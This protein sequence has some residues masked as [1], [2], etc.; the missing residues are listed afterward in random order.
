MTLPTIHPIDTITFSAPEE[1]VLQNNIKLFGFNGIQNDI[2]RIDLVFDAGRWTEQLPLQAEF[3]ARLFKS[4]TSRYNSF[5]ISEMIDTLGSTIKVGTGYNSF[6]V[7]VYC[8]NR[9]LEETLDYMLMCLNECSFPEKELSYQQRKSVANLLLSLEKNDYIADLEFR[10]QLFG[11]AHPYG[12]DTTKERIESLKQ[13][14]LFDYYNNEVCPE[15]CTLFIAGKYGKRELDIIDRTLGNWNKQPAGMSAAALPSI[16]IAATVPCTKR[17]RKEKSVQASL[18]IGNTMF[19]KTHADYAAFIL[20]NTLFGGYFSSRLMSNIREEKGL[21]YGIHSSLFTL[22]HTGIF[23]IQTDTNLENLDV[24]LREIYSEMERL[25]HE[26]VP[27]EEIVF[28]RNYL[29]GKYLSRTDGPFNQMDVFKS[30]FIENVNIHKFSEFV[31]TIRAADAVSL[32]RL[33]QHYLQ[34]EKMAEIVVG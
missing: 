3:V 30:Y 27:E 23:S 13:E 9:Y 11:D 19:N 26:P 22:K 4:G 1:L 20:L 14:H 25:Q 28:A 10:K 12:Y 29:L 7:A 17:I 8:M 34:K 2:L 33:A 24:C 5:E 15:K 32:Q 18:V 21:T 31:E 6:T 16:E